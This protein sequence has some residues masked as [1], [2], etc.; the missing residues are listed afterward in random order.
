MREVNEVVVV[1]AFFWRSYRTI[2]TVGKKNNAQA[3]LRQTVRL[4]H[5]ATIAL[6]IIDISESVL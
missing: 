3:G 1:R 2:Y 4:R 5:N 6:T